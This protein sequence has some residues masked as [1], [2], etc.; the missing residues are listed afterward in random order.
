MKE[1]GATEQNMDGWPNTYDHENHVKWLEP[2]WLEP[3]WLRTYVN[4]CLIYVLH[5]FHIYI[6]DMFYK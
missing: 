1:G 4:I 2:K 3:K 5:V 6:V